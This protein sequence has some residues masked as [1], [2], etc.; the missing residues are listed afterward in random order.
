MASTS[1]PPTSTHPSPLPL[2]G[3][4]HKQPALDALPPLS[5]CPAAKVL[6]AAQFAALHTA[7]IVAHPPDGVLFP[8]LHGLEGDNHAQ[9]TFFAAPARRRPPRFRGLVWVVAD[10]DEPRPAPLALPLEEEDDEDD[11]FSDDEEEDMEDELVPMDVD[12]DVRIVRGGDDLPPIAT[13]DGEADVHGEEEAGKHMHPV[14][15]RAAIQLQTVGLPLGSPSTA[16]N[17]STSTDGTF[18]PSPATDVQ[19]EM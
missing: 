6:A 4:V 18:F 16:G 19:M 9:N 2:H 13:L 7:H 1:P 10:E 12:P 11:D 14:H 8:F 5:S 17:S 15:H 3:L